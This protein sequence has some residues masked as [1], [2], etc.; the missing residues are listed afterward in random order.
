MLQ[1]QLAAR[2]N[3]QVTPLSTDAALAGEARE[4]IAASD[5]A[6][7]ATTD[8]AS[9]R[10]VAGLP[11]HVR[12]LDVSPAFRLH[13]D[14]VYGLP[15]LPGT[16]ERTR[17][18]FRVANPGCFATAALLVLSPLV[19][20][21]LLAP[22]APLYLDGTGGYSAGGG[23]M[24]ES[25]AQGMLETCATYSL[26]REHRHI[27]EISRHSRY[28][29]PLWFSPKIGNYERGVR[30]Q[31]PLADVDRDAA[32]AILAQAYAGT[33]IRVDN[34]VPSR[35]AADIWANRQGA[36]I[37]LIPQPGGTLAVCALDNL[38]KGAVDSAV[39]NL[40]VMLSNIASSPLA[41]S[42]T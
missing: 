3:L 4:V 25:A 13:A 16:V 33:A 14:W 22:H 34:A 29:G 5:I 38:L 17:D 42:K 6:V 2:E 12:V 9:E 32:L 27:A 28:E 31:I 18:A 39:C 36:G 23:K 19:R 35:I 7:L 1:E 21:G 40:D 8:F 41:T 11:A 15:E 10:V 37:W 24:I 30:M 20:A 26:S